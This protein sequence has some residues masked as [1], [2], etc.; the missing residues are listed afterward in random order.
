M[1]LRLLF[2]YERDENGS[3]KQKKKDKLFRS[4]LISRPVGRNE[5]EN[6]EKQ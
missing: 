4:Y 2:V 6:R 5:E 1:L 3:K